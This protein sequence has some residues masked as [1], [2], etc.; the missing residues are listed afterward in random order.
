MK[1]HRNPPDPAAKSRTEYF[2]LKKREARARA[3][4]ELGDDTFKAAR[5][6]EK[7][8]ERWLDQYLPLVFQWPSG[9]IEL[10]ARRRWSGHL[11]GSLDRLLR[12]GVPVVG[13]L[14]NSETLLRVP[15][16]FSGEPHDPNRPSHAEI[17]A[18]S[19]G[20]WLNAW[21]LSFEL[22]EH[23]R[24][25]GRHVDA[26]KRLRKALSQLL[27]L[28]AAE[29]PGHLGISVSH[30]LGGVL[31]CDCVC[32]IPRMLP[33]AQNPGVFWIVSLPESAL[34]D[35]KRRGYFNPDYVRECLAHWTALR[36]QFRIT[37]KTDLPDDWDD[38]LGQRK[39]RDYDL[40]EKR[41]LVLRGCSATVM[42]FDRKSELDQWW[43]EMGEQT[44]VRYWSDAGAG[45]VARPYVRECRTDFEA[46]LI[47]HLWRV[48]V[49][50]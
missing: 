41:V 8:R 5:R 7:R 13:D 43:K 30:I 34:Q 10:K 12:S 38:D 39:A 6:T 31:M 37:D 9:Q 40:A 50:V 23:C 19:L 27:G 22:R 17:Q 29:D 11:F 49:D 1:R 48:C 32:R 2:R 35:M 26:G 46:M 33:K 18:M 44:T 4:Q 16:V 3:R 42:C 14:P 25:A 21:I 28:L 36:D 15:D 45:T 47:R 20:T 24:H